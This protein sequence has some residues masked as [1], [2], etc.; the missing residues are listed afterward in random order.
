MGIGDKL[1]MLFLDESGTTVT[2][3]L[4]NEVDT[5]TVPEAPIATDATDITDTSFTANWNLQEN[6]TGYYL[7][8]ATDSGF[9]SMILT[10]HDAGNSS[11]HPITGLNDLTLYYYR[12]RAYNSAGTSVSSIT[13]EVTTALENV[14][15]ADGNV[16]TYVN[17]G[18][19]QWMVENLKTT[20]YNDGTAIPNI[21]DQGTWQADTTGGYCWYNND[22]ANKPIYGGL[23]NW[24]AMDNV[25]GLAP[26]GWRIPTNT[27]INTLLAFAGGGSI[28]GEKLKEAGMSHWS[29]SNGTNDYGFSLLGAGIRN[30]TFTLL[31]DF[32]FIGSATSYDLTNNYYFQVAQDNSTSASHWLKRMGMSIRCVRDI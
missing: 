16:Y 24:Y 28:A 11:S 29:S 27:D 32:A 25:H 1:T 5:V 23:Y 31:N 21:T 15:D 19:Q 20:K 22:I 14:I 13:M 30:T 26:T 17:I 4:V 7:D 2:I 12:V 6:S 18:T 3:D 9:T 8:V 10:N